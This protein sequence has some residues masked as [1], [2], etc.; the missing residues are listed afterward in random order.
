MVG[1]SGQPIFL[2][3][4]VFLPCWQL[5]QIMQWVNFSSSFICCEKKIRSWNQNCHVLLHMHICCFAGWYSKALIAFVAGLILN[6]NMLS[7]IR[8]ILIVNSG[9]ITWC[10]L[11][12]IYSF[13][14]MK[15]PC[16]PYFV[17]A[18]RIWYLV[19]QCY[20]SIF[21]GLWWMQVQMAFL[22]PSTTET[23]FSVKALK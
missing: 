20:N 8:I 4:L 22:S 11:S 19:T 12:R 3:C 10:T 2:C 16:F 13:L 7:H 15:F 9:P 21:S 23:G 18:F 14:M 5:G 6:V 17:L 1:N